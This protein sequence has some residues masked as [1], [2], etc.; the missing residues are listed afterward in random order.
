MSDAR[1]LDVSSLPPGAFGS[2]SLLW[3]GTMGIVLI[4]GTALRA[5]DR[6]LFLSHDAARRIWPPSGVIPPDLRW[7]TINTLVLLFSLVPNELAKRAG[8]HVELG[9][10]R[11]W[12]TVCVLFGVLFNLVRVF[13]FRHLNVMWDHSSYGSI[14][15]LL[16]GLHTTHIVTDFLDTIVLTALMFVGPV[17][18]RRF[19]DVEEN[20]AYWYFVVLAWLPIYGVIYWVPRLS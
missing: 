8:E 1:T 13:E 12:M 17:E 14:V 4:E 18:E 2:R 5:G 9:G 16:L 11:L 6:R 10:V 3:W 15:W 7:G 19:V 20:A